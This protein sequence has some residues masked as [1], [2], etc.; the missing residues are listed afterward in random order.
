MI[1]KTSYSVS[2]NRHDD[3]DDTFPTV[4]LREGRKRVKASNRSKALE[5]VI[6]I[7]LSAVEINGS[8]HITMPDDRIIIYYPQARKWR[9]KGKAKYYKC[10]NVKGAIT[11][12]KKNMNRNFE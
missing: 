9:L 10:W 6:S 1:E 12:Y 11:T 5:D 2:V 8:I 7:G 3:D 4:A